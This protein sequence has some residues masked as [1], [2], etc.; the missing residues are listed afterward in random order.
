M[1]TLQQIYDSF[2][3]GGRIS[4]EELLFAMNHFRQL[5]SML[6]VLG[7][8]F[9]IAAYEAKRVELGLYSYAVSRMLPQAI[10]PELR[11]A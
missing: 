2:L 7:D 11:I 10:K 3:D 5:H 8:R 9:A 6:I 1:R 4:N